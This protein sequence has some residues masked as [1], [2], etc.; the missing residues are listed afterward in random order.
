MEDDGCALGF[1]S[2]TDTVNEYDY[3]GPDGLASTAETVVKACACS[4][5][6]FGRL[7]PPPANAS[8]APGVLLAS[9]RRPQERLGLMACR[10]PAGT[11]VPSTM[12][13]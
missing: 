11:N 4:T 3:S 10:A 7:G 12:G 6:Y 5:I 2:G 1:D 13:K 8:R 9:L